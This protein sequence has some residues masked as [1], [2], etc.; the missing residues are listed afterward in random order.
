MRSKLLR[1]LSIAA[2]SVTMAGCGQGLKSTK[3][4]PPGSV[5][6][7]LDQSSLLQNRFAYQATLNNFGAS[8]LR[9]S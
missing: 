9:F 6:R 1:V 8:R 7:R 4:P 3:N 2:L 5:E